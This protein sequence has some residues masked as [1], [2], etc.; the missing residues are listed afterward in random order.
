[1]WCSHASKS[2]RQG[3]RPSRLGAQVG[4]PL[5]VVAPQDTPKGLGMGAFGCLDALAEALLA[6]LAPQDTPEGLSMGACACLDALAEA[7]LAV[8]APSDSPEGLGP[9]SFRALLQRIWSLL[10][11][12]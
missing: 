10:A 5:A 7:L 4:L 11:H 6:I 3:R 1:M 12:P 2:P 9:S 8:L